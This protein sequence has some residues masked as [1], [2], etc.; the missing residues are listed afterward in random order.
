MY[1]TIQD[2][3]LSYCLSKYTTMQECEQ[4]VI[5]TSPRFQITISPL[6]P[7]L[8]QVM[9]RL[10]QEA[11][12]VQ[13]IN[14]AVLEV[15]DE[16]MLLTFYRY[17][18][19][20]LRHQMISICAYH[21]DHQ[22]PLATLMPISPSFQH[23]WVVVESEQMYR[24]SRF[25]YLRRDEDGWNSLE[26]PLSHC[27]IRL[28]HVEAASLIYCLGTATS[29]SA[30]NASLFPEDRSAAGLLALLI[31]GNFVF[32]AT[33]E[34][35][36]SAE[37]N[38]TLRQWDFHDLLFHSRSREG[39]HNTPSG[40]TYRFFQDIEPQPALKQSSWPDTHPLFRPDLEK[41]CQ[42]EHGLTEV[43]ETRTSWREY[44][45]EPITAVQ[46]GE[47]LYR[48]AR[49][50]EVSQD[51]E[52]GDFTRRPYPGSGASYE[53]ELYLTIDRCKDLPAGFYWYNPLKHALAQIRPPNKETEK[54]LADACQA[55]GE[56]ARPQVLITLAARFQRVSW[57]YQSIAYALILKNVGVI[58]ATMYLVATAMNLA[59]CALG[60]GNSDLFS[61]LADTDYYKETSV[62]EFALG[63]R[64]EQLT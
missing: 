13:W 51:K 26:S 25:A 36:I 22:A 55:T 15:H 37:E 32:P 17:L 31:M 12:P 16:H 10:G 2:L 59:P 53:M 33:S 64:P 56:Y 43:L 21:T 49:V 38:E 11:R 42:E 19:S 30:L 4:G 7:G 3:P 27:H 35:G 20:L 1:L 54:L 34:G 46:L 45:Q 9:L 57:K 58:Y 44:G 40:A 23:Q 48:V 63:S 60:S 29:L 52:A 14:H 50:K 61:T 8:R 6:S 39:R 18:S 5:V 41:R 28:E 62:G 24:I 47:F